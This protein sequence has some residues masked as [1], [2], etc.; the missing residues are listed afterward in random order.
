MP[1][2]LIKMLT[3]A[4]LI[5]GFSAQALEIEDLGDGLY[6]FIDDRHR[7]VFLITPQGAIVT[8]PLNKKAA[9][10]LQQQI[11]TRFSFRF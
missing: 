7:S 8:N 5:I 2:L 1:R 3:G 4:L 10:W 9:T 6:R 11:N